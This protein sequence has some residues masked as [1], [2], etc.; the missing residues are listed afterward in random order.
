MPPT[1]DTASREPN[2]RAKRARRTRQALQAAALRLAAE[3]GYEATTME[4]VATAAGVSRRTVFNYFPTKADLFIRMPSSPEH[5]DI[6]RFV[7]SDG[8]LLDDLAALTANTD[9]SELVDPEDFRNLRLVLRD[10]PELT[11]ELQKHVRLYSSVIRAAI[12]RR[13]DADLSDPR[14]LAASA[15]SSALHKSAI[16]LWADQAGSDCPAGEDAPASGRRR[17]TARHLESVSDAVA[18][19]TTSLKELLAPHQ[20]AA[21]STSQTERTSRD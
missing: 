11:L 21:T 4:D 9:P 14:V 6:E 17:H 5:E 16:N 19:I 13:L 20:Q 2:L 7:A 10:N 12:A 15:L 1:S 18:L 8:D 3:R